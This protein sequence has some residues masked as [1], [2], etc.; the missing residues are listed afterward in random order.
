MRKRRR[1]KRPEPT[2]LINLGRPDICPWHV[3][4]ARLD[5]CLDCPEFRGAEGTGI[6]C[7]HVSGRE[8]KAQRA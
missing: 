1:P 6:R 3:H 8:P 7:A 4:P 2:Q 5:E